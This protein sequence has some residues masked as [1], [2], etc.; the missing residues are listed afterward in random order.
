MSRL[1][2]ITLAGNP[3]AAEVDYRGECLARL[4]GLKFLDWSRITDE[5]R[6]SA[7]ETHQR[8]IERLRADDRVAGATE[9]SKKA[10]AQLKV[11]HA[12][13]AIASVAPRAPR[14][15][16]HCEHLGPAPAD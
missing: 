7:A 15:L 2:C 13:R 6:A 9:E 1:Q 4:P 14:A 10:E 12:S 3:C 16:D 5:E 8:L 11:W